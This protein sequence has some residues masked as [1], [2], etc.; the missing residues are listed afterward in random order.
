[1]QNGAHFELSLK[2]RV[3][4]A[5]KPAGIG[6]PIACKT[7]LPACTVLSALDLVTAVILFAGSLLPSRAFQV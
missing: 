1:M 6:M 3:Q 4:S 2:R 7:T 5:G